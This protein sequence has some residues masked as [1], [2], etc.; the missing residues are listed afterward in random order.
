MLV[1]ADV[2]SPIDRTDLKL[3]YIQ[4][5]TSLP[6]KKNKPELRETGAT[7]TIAKSMG[8]IPIPGALETII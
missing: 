3:F 7:S 4:A 5:T 2:M 1:C 6:I 8:H